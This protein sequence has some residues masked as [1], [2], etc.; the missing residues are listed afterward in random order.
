MDYTNLRK[1]VLVALLAAGMLAGCQ[2]DGSEEQESPLSDEEEESVEVRPEVTFA[3]A[4]DEPIY[5]YVESQGLVE[6][7]REI[8]ISPRMSGYV[9][10]TNIVEGR[11]VQEG[12]T[13]LQFAERE[14]ALDLQE[15]RN[16]LAD[17]RQEYDLQKESEGW[18][19]TQRDDEALR[20]STGLAQAELN[21]ERI[22]MQMENTTI[23]APFTGTLAT[24]N[25]ITPGAYLSAGTEIATLID[26]RTLRVRFD[27]LEAEVTRIEPGMQAEINAPGGVQTT[28]EVDA[29]SPVVNSDTKT[30][31]VIISIDNP[32]G[33]IKKGM[34]VEGRVL[35][36]RHTGQVRFPRSAVLSRDG[37][38][39]LVFKYNPSNS[40]VEWIYVTPQFQN[41]EWVIV[42]HED[43]APGDTIAVDQHFSLSHLQLV[44]PM[45][46]SLEQQDAEEIGGN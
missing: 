39:T 1:S 35:V 34:T 38:R 5:T 40:E 41:R 24:E 12:D 10:T 30:G 26:D 6:A 22:Q 36:E 11:R 20:I 43:I 32:G 42:N 33:R 31:E 4:D 46:Q 9:T 3:V 2:G 29:V 25:R 19:G 44:T 16:N 18:T 15:A 14:L 21:L 37:G 28:G 27:V 45:M 23:T 17:A 7:D 8:T 13:L